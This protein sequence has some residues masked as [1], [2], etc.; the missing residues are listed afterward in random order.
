MTLKGLLA[1]YQTQEM[2]HSTPLSDTNFVKCHKQLGLPITEHHNLSL[3]D[4]LVSIS[5]GSLTLVLVLSPIMVA[6][7]AEV[8][9][10]CLYEGCCGRNA[11]D[12]IYLIV[13]PLFTG[14]SLIMV[15]G[16]IQTIPQR[17]SNLNS[18]F[19]FSDNA[20]AWVLSPCL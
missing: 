11:T 7:L 1:N 13:Y 19:N 3:V 16:S 17:I 6:I 18:R 2:T 14:Q 8:Y 12:W 20:R 10:C 9:K 4:I 15:D 5:G